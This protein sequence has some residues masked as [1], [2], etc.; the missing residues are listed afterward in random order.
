MV[1]NGE[2]C[3][4]ESLADLDG[5][6]VVVT[7]VTAT[8]PDSVAPPADAGPP[9]WLDVEMDVA[10]RM[11]FRWEPVQAHALDAGAVPPTAILPGDLADA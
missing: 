9:D 4:D 3:F 7:I 1:T 6:R 11:P 5:Q 8:A 2:L 10:F